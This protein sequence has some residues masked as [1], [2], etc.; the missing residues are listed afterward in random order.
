LNTEEKLPEGWVWTT[1]G[2]IRFDLAKGI[3]PSNFPEQ[4]FELYSVPSFDLGIPQIL[5]GKDIKS[6]KQ[7]VDSNTVL[8]CKINPR[9]NRAWIVGNFSAHTKIA[10]TEWLPFFNVPMIVPMYL[11]YHLRQNFVRDYFAANA[12]GLVVL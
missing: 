1:L 6:N 7:I 12:S 11:C 8:L 2:E 9:L 10:S 3:V 5:Q 4:F